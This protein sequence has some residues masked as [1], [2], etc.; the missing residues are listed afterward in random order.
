MLDGLI[1]DFLRRGAANQ[2]LSH[3]VQISNSMANA[4]SILVLGT[5]EL[6][7][8]VLESL[9]THT[10]RSSRSITVLLR[11]CSPSQHAISKREAQL[12]IFQRLGVSTLDGDIL[13]DPESKLRDLLSPFHTVIGCTGM[14]YP[15]GTQL[16][17]CRA[18][19]AAKI[20]RY[21]PWQ[22]GL[23][24]DKIGRGSS[25]DL[26]SEQL[27]VRDLLRSQAN[28]QWVIISTGIFMT[29][30]FEPS[31]GV[32][33]QEWRTVTALGSWENK[34]T[35]TSPHDIG[36]VVAEVTWTIPDLQGVIFTAGETVS[37]EGL[38][39][40]IE[41]HKDQEIHRRLAQIDQLKHELDADPTN[42]LRKYRVVFAEG[43]GVAWD[44]D[45]AFNKQR[46]MTMTRVQD[47]L[48]TL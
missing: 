35:V 20:S 12:A 39:Q 10:H 42:G 28:T 26:F 17:I 14:A 38:A 5:G 41:E 34:V 40:A 18:V 15:P 32:V 8:E 4:E 33:D 22:F 37:Y 36:R 29:F 48:Q 2:D 3:Q 7:F 6:G 21:L 46:G 47:W 9:A 19:L 45:Q 23:D 16:K 30:L 43:R 31:F 13:N 24:Y 27:D 44:E 1:L 11:P 25:Q